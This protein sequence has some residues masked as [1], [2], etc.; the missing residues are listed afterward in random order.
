MSEQWVY[1]GRWPG[2]NAKY[3]DVFR[4]G[5]GE[6]RAFKAGRSSEYVAGYIYDANYDRE[7]ELLHGTPQ[8]T[9]EKAEDATEIRLQAD[10]PAQRERVEREKRKAAKRV[11]L[12]SALAEVRQLATGLSHEARA[13]LLTHINRA[14]WDA[15]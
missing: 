7:A 2:Q 4:D 5:D 15:E 6:R 14:V 1:L 3:V 9:G 12:D 10:V 13:A 8:W 11:E